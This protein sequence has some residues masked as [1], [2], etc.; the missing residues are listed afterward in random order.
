MRK[1]LIFNKNY[2]VIT[3]LLLII[4]LFIALYVHDKFIRPY[5]GDLLVV[6]FIYTFC[7]SFLKISVNQAVA[8]VLFFSFSIE[9][10]QYIHFIN[11]L[12][13]QNNFIAK[14][15]L[16][17][18]FAWADFI[19]YLSGMLLVLLIEKYFLKNKKT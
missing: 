14:I 5:V 11:L 6:I 16:G 13:L 8:F 7:K 2:V 10:L 17:N 15:I 1:Y 18:S 4:E 3:L 19:A 9:A 12:G